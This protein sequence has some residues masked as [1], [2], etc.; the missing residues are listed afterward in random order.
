MGSAKKLGHSEKPKDIS[1][2]Q[3]SGGG[4]EMPPISSETSQQV[5]LGRILTIRLPKW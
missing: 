2:Y 5:S 4:S 3:L 1:L